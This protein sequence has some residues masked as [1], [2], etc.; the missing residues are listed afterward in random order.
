MFFCLY[1]A[2]DKEDSERSVEH[3]LSRAIGGVGWSTRDVCGECN[4]YCGQEVDRPFA[5]DP[6]VRAVRHRY[7]IPD[8][9]GKVPSAPRLYGQMTDG[10]AR[11]ELELGRTGP[12]VRRVP[13]RVSKDSGG[14][15]Y[16]V[17]PGEGERIAAL[18]VARLRRDLPP[19]YD[20]RTRIE[21]IE[22][23]DD[24]ARI[25]LS[26]SIH[27]WPRMAA[28][29][30]LS[31]GARGMDKNWIRGAW[32]DW[33]RGILRGSPTSAPDPRVYLRALPEP[34]GDTDELAMLVDPPH[35]TIFFSGEAPVCLMVHLFGTWRYVVPLGPADCRDRPAWEFDPR[36]G[37]ALEMEFIELAVAG[38]ERSAA[39][40]RA[41]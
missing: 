26:M 15:S 34:I 10:G 4:R 33:L 28:K 29:L 12:K 38:A 11:A 17:E 31:L 25:E 5:E 36:R 35:H 18:R 9:R 2:T 39:G 21:E 41:H 13:Y 27:L 32:A 20:V 22:L 6:S 7:E 23:P 37:S 24:E 40:G 3:P 8:S 14:E 1:C 19:G 30:G 16:I